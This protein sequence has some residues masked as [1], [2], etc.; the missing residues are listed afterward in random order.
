MISPRSGRTTAIGRILNPEV[1]DRWSVRRS[2]RLVGRHLHVAQE[3]LSTLKFF[4]ILARQA[5]VVELAEIDNLHP[6][7]RYQFMPGHAGPTDGLFEDAMD[8]PGGCSVSSV[9]AF[10][11]EPKTAPGRILDPV[12]VA[13][14]GA[15]GVLGRA[16]PFGA[17]TFGSVGM[18]DVVDGVAPVELHRRI[19]GYRHRGLDRLG[20]SE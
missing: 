15:I 2:C 14:M 9:E 17:N 13:Q 10:A 20:S 6:I 16:P 3:H 5:Q 12:V 8:E 4:I 19:V 11:I 1:T 7:G 18:D